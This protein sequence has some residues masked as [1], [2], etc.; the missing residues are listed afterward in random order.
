MLLV[1]TPVQGASAPEKIKKAIELVDKLPGIDVIVVTRGGGS[2]EDLMA[3]NTELVGR[4][5]DF[6]H[7][8]G[9]PDAQVDVV[10][11]TLQPSGDVAL[12]LRFRAGP[13]VRIRDVR[14][15]GH[16]KTNDAVILERVGLAAGDLYRAG[17]VRETFERLYRTGLFREI[18]LLLE[19]ED[20][21]ERDLV[22]DERER[23]R[24]GVQDVEDPV[25]VDPGV[26]TGIDAGK[27]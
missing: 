17:A 6:L 26:Q 20:G 14:L 7:E 23:A 25:L 5:V 18:R 1:P 10:D 3:Y 8:R 4:A 12:R 15:A 22:I 21:A 9:Y 13:R 2:T 24:D 16:G 19:P 11:R 27:R